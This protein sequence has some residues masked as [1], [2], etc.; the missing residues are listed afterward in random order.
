MCRTRWLACVVAAA[1]TGA[2]A[3][4]LIWRPW[5]EGR[6]ARDDWSQVD[7]RLETQR[8]Q[9]LERLRQALRGRR[10]AK[11]RAIAEVREGRRTLWEA[12][13]VFR[14]ADE[15]FPTGSPTLDLDGYCLQVI[16]QVRW[17]A[18]SRM[19]PDLACLLEAELDELRQ[20]GFSTPLPR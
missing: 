3:A 12:A 4:A 20:D 6:P 13:A 19:R 8:R 17:S 16:G 18:H 2:A 14:D 5:G 15:L 1:L 11:E 9:E 10:L 7:M